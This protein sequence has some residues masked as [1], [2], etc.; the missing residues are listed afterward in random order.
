MVCFS[1]WPICIDTWGARKLLTQ[2]YSCY[3][4]LRRNNKEWELHPT[5]S[6][7][8]PSSEVL[9]FECLCRNCSAL[10]SEKSAMLLKENPSGM[11]EL[12]QKLSDAIALSFRK[13]RCSEHCVWFYNNLLPQATEV[14][15]V[16]KVRNVAGSSCYW[17]YCWKRANQG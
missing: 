11:F 4:L 17:V 12:K 1:Q 13:H 15:L 5:D 16:S 10:V 8:H 6:P 14:H 9:T 3:T 2:L 7:L